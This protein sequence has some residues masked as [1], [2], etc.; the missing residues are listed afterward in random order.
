M[1]YEVWDTDTA[2]IVGEFS[3]EDAALALVRDMVAVGGR[4]SVR[5]WTLAAA[6]DSGATTTI[7]RGAALARRA[8]L[9][10]A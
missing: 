2:T 8:Q 10:P 6:D 4:R 1:R 7:A 3:T 9:A 5:D